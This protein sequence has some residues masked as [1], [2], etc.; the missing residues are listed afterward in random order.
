M[1]L[2][3][4]STFNTEQLIDVCA[5]DSYNFNKKYRFSLMYSFLSIRNNIR[6]AITVKSVEN[7]SLPSIAELFNSVTWLEREN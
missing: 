6:I 4:N 3:H 1:F 7:K 2:K 5:I